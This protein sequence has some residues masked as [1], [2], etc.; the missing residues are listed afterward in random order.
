MGLKFVSIPQLIKFK[1]RRAEPKD[2]V[3][4]KMLRQFLKKNRLSIR[5]ALLQFQNNWLRAKRHWERKIKDNLFVKP[6][7][8]LHL[9]DAFS[10]VRRRLSKCFHGGGE[11]K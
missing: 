9:Y 3:D 6:M 2:I 1:E 8:F 4:A 11:D 5:I 7:R 10:A